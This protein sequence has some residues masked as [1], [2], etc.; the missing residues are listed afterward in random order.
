MAGAVLLTVLHA[1]KPRG[2][3][4]VRGALEAV[5][6][7]VFVSS[8]LRD[9]YPKCD[10]VVALDGWDRM[11]IEA[12]HR[13]IEQL[14]PRAPTV[15]IVTVPA[16]GMR[17]A[18]AVE[19]ALD[20]GFD[21]CVRWPV[22]MAELRARIRV[23]LRQARLC[24]SLAPSPISLNPELFTVRCEPLGATRLTP[25]EFRLFLR[26]HER[27]GRWT[28]SKLL[29]EAIAMGRRSGVTPV[30]VHIH[31]IRKKLQQAAWRLESDHQLGYRIECGPSVAPV[32]EKSERSTAGLCNS[33]IDDARGLICDDLVD[34]N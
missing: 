15:A 11:P 29:L 31:A 22:E 1:H 8:G 28:S 3:E 32:G 21:D 16:S 33:S 27:A 24:E 5:L 9:D 7:A 10:L 13:R 18:S 2:L 34:E 19:R 26:L 30:A 20:A 12:T 14:F 23:R 4:A 17:G 25:A 6:S